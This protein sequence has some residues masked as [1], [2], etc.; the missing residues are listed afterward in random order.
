[1]NDQGVVL[2]GE[3]AQAF[4]RYKYVELFTVAALVVVLVALLG[5][6]TYYMITR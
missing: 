2:L 1:M 5:F 6:L 4:V 3:A